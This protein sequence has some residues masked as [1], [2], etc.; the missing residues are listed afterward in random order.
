MVIIQRIS[1]GLDPRLSFAFAVFFFFFFSLLH[2][3]QRGQ[4]LL[5]TYYLTLFTHCSDTVHGTYSHFIQKKIKI[6]NGSHGTIHIFKN[7]FV[8]I[9]SVFSFNKNKLYPNG[10]LESTN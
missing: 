2:A 3:F 10:L 7:Y 5:F 6:E 8:T 4:N 9:F 1:V